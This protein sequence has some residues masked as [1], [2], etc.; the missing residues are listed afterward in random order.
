MPSI[1]HAVG[2]GQ[3]ND[4]TD[5]LVIRALLNKFLLLGLIEDEKGDNVWPIAP[6][7]DVDA[8]MDRAIRA[9]QRQVCG[10]SP[11]GVISPGKSTI[12]MLNG[13]LSAASSSSVLDRLLP[14]GRGIRKEAAAARV[15]LPA[16]S[17]TNWLSLRWKWPQGC[18]Y[19]TG[20]YGATTGQ[21][22]GHDARPDNVALCKTDLYGNDL[23]VFAAKGWQ[24]GLPRALQAT[25]RSTAGSHRTRSCSS[26]MSP[27]CKSSRISASRRY[28]MGLRTFERFESDGDGSLED[29]RHARVQPAGP[30]LCGVV[31]PPSRAGRTSFRATQAGSPSSGKIVRSE[32]HFD[33]IGFVNYCIAKAWGKPNW[34]YGYDTYR[35]NPGNCYGRASR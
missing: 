26:A 17:V 1:D 20:G 28:W 18:R 25:S 9:F 6:F 19:I 2:L 4:T 33:C 32:R 5:V 23:A 24:E 21:S 22:D 27:G 13:P 11:D 30:R 34:Q 8:S 14:L 29:L 12:Q 31:H 16:P 3:T 15:R 10:F 7:G 35:D